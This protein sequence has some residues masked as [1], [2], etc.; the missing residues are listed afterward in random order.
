MKRSLSIILVVVLL[1][2]TMLSSCNNKKDKDVKEPTVIDK[3]SAAMDNVA[4]YE[5]DG[6]LEM[7]AYVSAQ[8]M[9][10]KGVSKEIYSRDNDGKLYYYSSDDATIKCMGQE[11]VGTS[12]EAYN[13]GYYL[14]KYKMNDLNSKRLR[15]ALTEE[16]FLDY[17]NNEE[18]N[19]SFLTG[20]NQ[21]SFTVNEDKT[22]SIK[23]WQYDSKIISKINANYGFP[24]ENAGGK[25]T[26]ISVTIN[27]EENFILKEI[28]V[29]F[30]F[31][32]TEFS[33]SQKMTFSKY[34]NA[35]KV[36]N[37]ILPGDYTI[38]DD[39]RIAPMLITLLGDRKNLE[40]GSFSMSSVQ[41]YYSDAQWIVK[42][43]KDSKVSYG[44]DNGK[45]YFNIET[46]SNG[47]KTVS[48]Y[49]DGKFKSDD[50]EMD[51]SDFDAKAVIDSLID[52]YGYSPLAINSITKTV[53]NGG[54]VYVIQ[55]SYT[56]LTC[57]VR[58]SKIES[59]KYESGSKQEIIVNF[60]D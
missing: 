5:M 24:L 57:F 2:L 44:V 9:E 53:E 19:P 32:N 27:A 28:L 56:T 23:L 33:G 8:K 48:T 38:V 54:D 6:V 51:L 40:N 14:F 59:L 4:S 21:S 25:I 39:A 11:T 52:P 12:I 26:D 13:E 60:E 46:E 42:E 47:K 41:K 16:E 22:H 1:S 49:R 29:D 37:T 7:V 58:N 17:K 45:Y 30:T 34:N 18:L 20:Y 3:I 10:I 15:T 36:L 43:K 50:T 31:S 35:E 55:L